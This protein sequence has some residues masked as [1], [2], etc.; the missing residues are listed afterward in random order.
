[1]APYLLEDRDILG[2]KV[3]FDG[4]AYVVIGVMPAGFAFPDSGAEFWI[5][6]VFPQGA[7]L[8]VTARIRDGVP[9]DA[10]S[11]EISMLLHRV[12][13]SSPFAGAAPPPPPP[14]LPSGGRRRTL[15][16]VLAQPPVSLVPLPQPGA[17][18]RAQEP[19]RVRLVGF[20]DFVVGSTK[21]A[22]LVISAAVGFVL[23]IACVN[24]ANLLLARSAG[25][26]REFSV[27]L[28]LG[29]S[30]ARLIRQL[31]TE[32][33]LLA[34]AGGVAGAGLA[35][36]AVRMV[37]ALGQALPRTGFGPSFGLPRVEE[38]E[39]DVAVLAFTAALSMMAGLAAG[40]FPAFRYSGPTPL[41]EALRIGSSTTAS[42]TRWIRRPRASAVLVV[43]ELALA[44]V[45]FVGAALLIHSFLKLSNVYPGYKAAGL[46]TFQ[47]V[48]PPGRDFVMFRDNL[49]SRL[50]ALPG[51]QGVACSDQI[52]MG[53]RRGTVYLSTS[54]GAPTGPPPPPSPG[55]G[56]P[57]QY[58][59][60]RIVSHDF[61]QVMDI[62]VIQGRGFSE[63]DVASH[64]NVL[65]INRALAR[66]DY[67]GADPVGKT[68][69]VVGQSP[70]EVIGVADDI[71][72]SG[73]DQEPGP[74]IFIERRQFETL[75]AARPRLSP[76]FVV[77]TDLD[78]ATIV[79][80][81][82]DIV[83]QLDRQATLD[84]VAT[85]EQIVSNTIVKP[86]FNAVLV[87]TFAGVAGLLALV[88][89]YGV[90]AYAVRQRSR[91]IGVRTALGASGGAILLLIL[92]QGWT[93]ASVGIALG[94]LASMATTRYLT[95]MLFG[96]TPLDAPTY[97]TVTIVFAIVSSL[98]SYLPARRATR[99]DP[100]LALRHE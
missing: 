15:E 27:R 12:R 52:P 19:P 28:A 10:A 33:A 81:I 50:A 32:S 97:I 20:Q 40:L 9:R 26:H 24:V 54:P 44:T 88:G 1:V 29:A 13:T 78:A 46:L 72:Q 55:G 30:R 80:A 75:T 63:E 7:R 18:R 74:Q 35:F 67:L 8:V 68:V 65:I 51:I 22:L 56:G 31:L 71:R 34:I 2:Q 79:P 84:G 4:T 5:P 64:S 91:E 96:L 92:R 85:M 21:N 14:P 94:L 37:R 38:V 57:P 86:R 11:H 39:I 66:S 69:Y 82:R 90:M 23:L 53:N 61:F 77:R 41:E 59:D 73:L 3:L 42:W 87:G 83:K 25:R 98:A 6:F 47:V 60:L 62:R 49:Y 17:I 48:L 100:V 76:Y 36:G 99:L 45:L 89:I 93:L 43:T 95:G 70:W 16:E 58:P